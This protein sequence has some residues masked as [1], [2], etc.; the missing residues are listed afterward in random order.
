MND[1]TVQIHRRIDDPSAPRLLRKYYAGSYTGSRFDTAAQLQSP[2]TDRFTAHDFAAVATLSVPL[3]GRA[4]SGLIDNDAGL[5]DLLATVPHVDLAQAS[6]ADLERLYALQAALDKIVDVGHVTRSK[7]LA[8]KRP[9][10]VPI[11]DKYVLSALIGRDSGDFTRPLRD[12]LANDPSITERL[13][14]LRGLTDVVD[15]T[16]LRV[17]DVVV[18]MTEHGDSQVPD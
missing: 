17:L 9:R 13:N 2:E 7:L 1:L 4:V 14:A 11:R 8:H 18:W 15:I 12:S 16:P 5:T 10:L 6:D 3:T